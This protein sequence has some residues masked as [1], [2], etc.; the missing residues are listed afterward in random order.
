[1]NDVEPGDTGTPDTGTPDTGTPNTGSSDT[2]EATGD[3]T[4]SSA[5]GCASGA[6]GGWIWLAGLGVLRLRRR[7]EPLFQC[8]RVPCVS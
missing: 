3:E 5:C 7:S 1:M 2:D 4:P 8:L 6:A